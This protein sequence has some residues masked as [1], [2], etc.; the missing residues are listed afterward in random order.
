MSSRQLEPTKD[1]K[2]KKTVSPNTHTAGVHRAGERRDEGAGVGRFMQRTVVEG[3]LLSGRIRSRVEDH[4][5]HG[6]GGVYVLE[7]RSVDVF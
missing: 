6:S 7:W 1:V 3:I 4:A 2:T 5:N